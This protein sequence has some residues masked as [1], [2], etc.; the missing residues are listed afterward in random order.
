MHEIDN[1]E[2]ECHER[3]KLIQQSKVVD[4][5]KALNESNEL[6]SKSNRLLKQF[7]IDQTS[8]IDIV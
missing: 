1:Y 2:K 7:K 5:E 8:V 3:F 6:F 4:I